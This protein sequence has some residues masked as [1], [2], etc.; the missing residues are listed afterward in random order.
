MFSQGC[1]HLRKINVALSMTQLENSIGPGT[2]D[3]LVVLVQV[4]EMTIQKELLQVFFLFCILL[5]VKTSRGSLYRTQ[6][7]VIGLNVQTLFIDRTILF[8]P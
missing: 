3:P 8:S 2:E 7:Q 1:A 5:E 4:Q 6:F